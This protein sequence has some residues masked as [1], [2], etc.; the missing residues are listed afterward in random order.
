MPADVMGV[1]YVTSDE[2]LVGTPVA[3]DLFQFANGIN[4]SGPLGFQAG[5]GSANPKDPNYSPM[6]RISFVEWN[7]AEKDAKVLQTINDVASAQREGLIS[8]SQPFDGRHVVNCPFFDSSVIQEYQ[9]RIIDDGDSGDGTMASLENM[10]SSAGD[11]IVDVSIQQGAAALTDTAFEPNPVNIKL[12]D[13]IKWT[14]NDN[15]LHTV[16]EGNPD[17]GQVSEGFAS[18]IIAPGGTFEYKIGKMGTFDYYCK[19][20]P[21]MIEKVVVLVS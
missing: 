6:W 10:T 2:K 12:G 8:V 7:N 16:I 21:N 19:L 15:T 1:P 11:D 5:I 4:G 20:H 13:T 3:I 18:D 14:N 17:T 9:S